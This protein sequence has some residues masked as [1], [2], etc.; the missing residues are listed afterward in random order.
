MRSLLD[1]ILWLMFY[2]GIFGFV[3]PMPMF[4]MDQSNIKLYLSF[5]GLNDP[6]NQIDHVLLL[7]F[8]MFFT[9]PIGMLFITLVFKISERVCK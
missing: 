2:V 1:I 3:W 4:F 8:W 9:A 7:Y 5:L 6:K